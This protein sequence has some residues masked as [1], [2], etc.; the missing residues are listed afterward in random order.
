MRVGV[1][2][3]CLQ[4]AW[5]TGVGEYALQTLRHLVRSEPDWRFSGY[6]N[7]FGKHELPGELPAEVA[8]QRNRL[9][10][11]LNNLRLWLG[12]GPA[13]ARSLGLR[14]APDVMWF[15]NPLFAS[16]DATPTVQTVHDLALLRYPGF[17]PRRGRLWYVPMVRNLLRRNLPDS[18]AIVAVSRHTA[19]DLLELYPR[20]QGR[21]TVAYP[22]VEERFFADSTADEVARVRRKYRLPDAYLLSLG[23]VEPRKNYDM[24]LRAFESYVSGGDRETGLVIAGAWGWRTESFRRALAGS[25]AR[26][27]VFVVGYVDPKDK[28]A[29]YAGARLFLYPSQ[30]EGFGMPVAEAMASGTAVVASLSSSL[31]EVVGEAGVLVSPLRAEQW[32]QAIAWLMSDGASRQRYAEAGRARAR[33][34]S[35]NGTAGVYRRVFRE[36]SQGTYAGSY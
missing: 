7:S 30:Y 5:R 8:V 2:I 23:T 21:I 36:L 28:P 34:Y 35:W 15:P 14:G 20:W 19:Q 29:L 9:P 25:P 18:S 22:G 17:F 4:D 6:S 1:D 31:P 3:R 10:N 27:R 32:A 24:L 11:K 33:D 26:D 13:P 16:F 12:A